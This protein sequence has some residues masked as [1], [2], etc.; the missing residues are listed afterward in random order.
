M[1]ELLVVIAII[2]VLISLLLPAVQQAREA[3][4]R[5]QC[6]NNLK[7]LGLALHNYHDTHNVFPPG[8][9]AI[10][11]TNIAVNPSGPEPSRTNVTGGWGWGTFI[12]PFLDQAPLYSALNPTGGNFPATPND[13]TKTVL[14]IFQCPTEASPALHFATPL[15]GDGASNGH[16]RSS[17][18]GVCGSGANADYANKS[19]L[20]TRG[21]LWYNSDARIR[22]V[23]DG[24]SNTMMV[25]E[26]FWD[27]TTSELRRGSVWVGKCPGGPNNAGNKYAVLIRVENNPDWL[28]N[29]LNNNSASS[30]HG[31]VRGAGIGAGDTGTVR[32]GG[33]GIHILMGDGGVR[34]VSENLHG[35]TWQRLGQM[36]DGE[37]IGEF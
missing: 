14:P 22:D 17:Y 15:G 11:N 37:V 33:F 25:V 12:L 4:R 29:G 8:T 34:L 1:I 32:K 36:S 31:G 16:A 24:M 6:K 28:I 21:M 5:S 35:P 26:R 30:M 10:L 2:A 23:A 7:Q 20:Q 13:L 18:A 19:P 3:A 9:L 27:G